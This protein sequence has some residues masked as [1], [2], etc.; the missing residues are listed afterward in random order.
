MIPRLTLVTV[1]TVPYPCN[2]NVDEVTTYIRCHLIDIV[3]VLT[4]STSFKVDSDYVDR[5]IVLFLCLKTMNLFGSFQ[6]FYATLVG[7]RTVRMAVI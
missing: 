3:T 1:K 6:S 7:V 4:V 5:L 2:N